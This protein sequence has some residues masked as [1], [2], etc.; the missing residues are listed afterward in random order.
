MAVVTKKKVSTNALTSEQIK[1]INLL[2]PVGS[3]YETS[4]TS[5]NPNTAWVGTWTY[6]TS[7]SIRKWHRTAA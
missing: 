7:G 6:T 4:D 3:Y 5:F 2:Y 1:A